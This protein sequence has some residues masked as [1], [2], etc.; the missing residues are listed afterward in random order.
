MK[1]KSIVSWCVMVMG[2]PLI[3]RKWCRLAF[4]ATS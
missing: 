4:R 1:V 2:L 3:A